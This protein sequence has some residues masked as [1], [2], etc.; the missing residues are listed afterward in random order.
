MSYAD[1]PTIKNSKQEDVIDI[2]SFYT[3]FKDFLYNVADNAINRIIR[4]KL[5]A[6]L[7]KFDAIS[8]F[9]P[10]VYEP[11]YNPNTNTLAILLEC[12]EEDS[13]NVNGFQ[14]QRIEDNNFNIF[15]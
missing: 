9:K 13:L 15:D 12:N 11:F 1:I 2:A 7:T 14:F 8:H 6:K 3:N 10:K 5:Q 4:E